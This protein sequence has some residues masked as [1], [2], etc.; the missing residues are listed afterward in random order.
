MR[1]RTS[2]SRK[3]DIV[4][5][6]EASPVRCTFGRG[7][8]GLSQQPEETS[9]PPTAPSNGGSN[10]RSKRTG[11]IVGVVLAV[12]FVVGGVT[13]TVL[14]MNH[15]ADVAAAERQAAAKREAA[16]EAAAAKAKQEERE[17][18]E[19]ARREEI[20]DSCVKQIKPF[21]DALNVIDARLD[22][23]LSQQEY[24]DLL[25]AASVAYSRIEA[26]ELGR[27]ACLS[28]GAKLEDA[29]NSYNTVAS[30]WGDCIFDYS[31]DVDDLDPMMQKNWAAAAR[32][33]GQAERHI[34]TLDPENP[35]ADGPDQDT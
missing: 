10:R 15:R 32:S 9:V 2:R 13:A 28:A 14:I 35:A 5:V 18:A 17:A 4:E 33:I 21:L 25:G 12:L 16:A 30:P 6:S 34:D 20:Y 7:R 31:C 27:G 24:S 29:F 1:H 26:S 8:I 19:I 11:P 22:V 3:A 23:G